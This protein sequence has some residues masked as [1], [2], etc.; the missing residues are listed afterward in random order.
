MKNLT[1]ADK[2]CTMFSK[3]KVADD[4]VAKMKSIYCVNSLSLSVQA[5]RKHHCYPRT[6][7]GPYTS[8]EVGF[9]S[10]KPPE[11][12]RTYC[13]GDFD[14]KP[15]D[16]VYLNVPMNLITEFIDQHGGIK[17]EESPQHILPEVKGP[18]KRSVLEQRRFNITMADMGLSF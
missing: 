10:R 4:T 8:F 11:S 18:V 1:T 5:S 3:R 15:S 14:N 6:N 16:T 7:A 12:W 9:P 17:A 13:K 2:I